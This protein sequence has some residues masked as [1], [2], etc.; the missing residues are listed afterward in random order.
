M[1][2]INIMI[3][4]LAISAW[5]WYRTTSSFSDENFFA[6][7]LSRKPSL[8][9]FMNHV[10]LYQKTYTSAEQLANTVHNNDALDTC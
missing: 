7:Q 6:Q 1:E 10:R 4:I 9:S 2:I 8:E 3:I 5:I